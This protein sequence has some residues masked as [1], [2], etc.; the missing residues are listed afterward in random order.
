M[1][2]NNPPENSAANNIPMSDLPV[3]EDYPY[4]KYKRLASSLPRMRSLSM[5]P[6]T[7]VYAS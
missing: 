6:A 1:A 5:R 7:A 2:A 4:I 3:F